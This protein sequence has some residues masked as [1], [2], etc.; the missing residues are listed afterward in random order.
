MIIV[1]IKKKSNTAQVNKNTLISKT[2]H[3]A[4]PIPSRSTLSPQSRRD[5]DAHDRAHAT[6]RPPLALT[7]M[8]MM[9]RRTMMMMMMAMIIMEVGRRRTSKSSKRSKGG[10]S[11]RNSRSW[12][13]KGGRR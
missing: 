6:H 1:K 3:N 5:A 13:M 2:T 9:K 7:P 4:H 10:G 12:K 11:R 8:P